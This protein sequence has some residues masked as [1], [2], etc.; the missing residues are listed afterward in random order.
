MRK[1]LIAGIDH[2][3]HR[4]PLTGCVND[5][6]AMRGALAENGDGS[7]NFDCEML[8]AMDQASA[9]RLP[10]RC[11]PAMPIRP[12]WLCSILRAMAQ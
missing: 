2:Y 10:R 12:M 5:A 9:V 1:A 11:L 8:L 6:L 7:R 3:Q 4:K